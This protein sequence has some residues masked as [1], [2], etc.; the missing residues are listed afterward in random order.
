MIINHL[1]TLGVRSL[2]KTVHIFSLEDTMVIKKEL[3]RFFV[4]ARNVE[5]HMGIEAPTRCR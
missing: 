1:A 2:R 5:N 3:L 4:E